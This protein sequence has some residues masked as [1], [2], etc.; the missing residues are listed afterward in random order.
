MDAM[1][2]HLIE[3]PI[4]LRDL[5]QWA[6]RRELARQGYDEGL[7]LHHL[8]GEA[9]GPAALQPFR[10]MVAPRARVGTVYAY[11]SQD[12]ETLRCQA[13]TSLTPAVAEVMALDRLRSLPRPSSG[14]VVGQRLGFDLRLRPVVRLASALS[15]QD[16]NGAPVSFRKGAEVDA[17]LARI[18]RGEAATR[19][20]V[21]LD[22]LAER[23]ASTASLDRAASR[24]ASFQ[25][26]VIRR[27]GRRLEGPDAVIH[28]TLTIVDPA[29]FAAMLA[30]GVGRHRAYGYGMVLLRPPQR[31]GTC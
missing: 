3:L 25:R 7:A 21:Y 27:D 28:G 13:A 31:R 17:F 16:E 11:A 2:F 12:A 30:R 6:G 8:L 23:L 4:A 10:L 18:L 26:S 20:A 24:L 29:A 15:G 5:H 9:F 14:W 19:E 1:T 22:W